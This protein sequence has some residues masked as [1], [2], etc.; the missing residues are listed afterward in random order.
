MGLTP[1]VN[2]RL[3]PMMNTSALRLTY[4][5]LR[6]LPDDGRRHEIV[7]GE[8]WVSPSP[9]TRHQI[10][11]GNLYFLI[12]EHLERHDEGMVLVA[13][14]DVVFSMFDVVVPDLIFLSRAN[15]RRLTA[16]HLRGAPDVAV[17]VA[18]PGTR[19]RDDGLKLRLY[20]RFD[21]GEYWVVDPIGE[22]VRVHR[23]RASR[24]VPAEIVARSADGVL[25]TPLM[26]GLRMPLDRVCS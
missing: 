19:R 22:R 18:S 16:R 7:N 21:V 15:A 3:K 24:L 2:T 25:H 13:P 17:E 14:Y 8:H 11:V 23:R 10:V 12:R 20:E 6:R 4:H 5:D 9:N 1:R 26:P